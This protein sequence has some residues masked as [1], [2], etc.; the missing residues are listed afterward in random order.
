MAR[1]RFLVAKALV[2]ADRERER[3]VTLARDALETLQTTATT[4]PL[5]EEIEAWLDA[6]RTEQD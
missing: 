5:I 3:A 4:D 6:Q 1:T 2:A